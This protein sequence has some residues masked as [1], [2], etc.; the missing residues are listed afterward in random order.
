MH[1]LV[2]RDDKHGTLYGSLDAVTQKHSTLLV[3]AIILSL[4]RAHLTC[5]DAFVTCQAFGWQHCL[6]QP[7]LGL[8]SALQQCLWVRQC[9]HE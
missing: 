6:Q 8:T 9:A 3:S 5:V 4:H 7:C 2:Y 1:F